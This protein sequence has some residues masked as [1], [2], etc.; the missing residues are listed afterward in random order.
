MTKRMA[1]KVAKM[2][3]TGHKVDR[4]VTGFEYD[5]YMPYNDGTPGVDMTYIHFPWKVEREILR[6]A[7]KSGWD[8]C[9]WG[10][11]LLVSVDTSEMERY[12][13]EFNPPHCW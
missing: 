2:Y 11:P 1:K 10:N 6:Q 5:T 13:A 7:K 3:L 9:H 8:G 4:F 12:E